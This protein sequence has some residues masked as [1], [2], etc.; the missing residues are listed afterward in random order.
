MEEL[1]RARF[2]VHPISGNDTI[3]FRQVAIT[4]ESLWYY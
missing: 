3:E 2:P 4:N 1:N